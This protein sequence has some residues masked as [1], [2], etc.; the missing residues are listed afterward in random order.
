[1]L[2]IGNAA[3]AEFTF[4]FAHVLM[5]DVPAAVAAQMVAKEV[6]EKSRGRI[7]IKVYPAGQLGG[8][9]EI[10]EQITMNMAQIG[11]PPTATLGNFE[12]RIQLIDLPYIFPNREAL[13]AVL[14][15]EVG[16]EL[17]AS[18]E[19]QDLK[20]VCYWENGFRHMTNNVRS[21][22]TPADLKSVRMRTMQ[23]PAIIEQYKTWGANPIPIAFSETYNALQ[24]GVADGQENPLSN[25]D[26][27]RFYEV[28]KYLT[29]SG[30]SYHGYALIVNKTA[31]NKLPADLKKIMEESLIKGRDFVRQEVQRQEVEILARFKKQLKVNELTPEGTAAF[32][33]LSQNV[34]KR[35]EDVVSASL[36]SRTYQ[37]TKGK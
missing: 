36:L 34:H 13:K 35:L 5:N 8:D 14:D 2:T 31:W 30:H 6:A 10:I 7:E 20:G 1:L 3:A 15:H 22:Y 29:L 32:I 25:I 23:S 19:K 4:K 24:Q 21:I 12:P 9:L 26:K 16:K 28:Q 17:L 11:I 27:M 37:I 33:K 18:L